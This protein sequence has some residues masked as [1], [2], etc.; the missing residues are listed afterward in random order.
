MG[1][2]EGGGEVSD[3]LE[4]ADEGGFAYKE[5]DEMGDYTIGFTFEVAE[6]SGKRGDEASR[7]GEDLD[8]NEED[9]GFGDF[10]GFA[11]GIGGDFKQRK[12]VVG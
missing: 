5:L 12:E 7:V 9:I 11:E 1:G 8:W 10:K 6:E 4:A 3:C 2:D